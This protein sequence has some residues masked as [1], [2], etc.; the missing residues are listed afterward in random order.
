M[1]ILHGG[2]SELF[3]RAKRRRRGGGERWQ[4]VTIIIYLFSFNLDHNTAD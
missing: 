2:H 4:L 3:E 1:Q